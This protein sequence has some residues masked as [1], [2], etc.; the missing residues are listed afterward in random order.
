MEASVRT[1]AIDDSNIVERVAR[2]FSSVR[3]ARPDYT[4]LAAELE[5]TIPF[6]VFGVTLLRYD[7]Q[8]VRVTICQ[9]QG[10]A[11]SATYRQHPLRD[12]Q[13]D[14]LINAPAALI[15]NYPEGLDGTPAEC[16]DALSGF[17]HLHSSF[18]A[19][20]ITEGE[21]IL[22]TLELGSSRLHAYESYALRRLIGAVVRVLANAIEGAQEGGSAAIQNRQ[23]EALKSVSAAL[24]SQADLRTVLSAITGGLAQSLS[25]ATAIVTFDPQTG[26][27]S[28][29]AQTGFDEARLRPVI[30][31]AEAAEV[32]D[33]VRVS[34]FERKVCISNDVATDT[35][36]LAS[37]SFADQLGMR[38]IASQPLVA[39]SR[40]HGALLLCSPEAGGFTPLKTDIL[41]LF[42]T[43]AAIAYLT[44]GAEDT[45]ARTEM[46]D[47]LSRLL[48]HIKQTP[49]Q[50]NDALWV[51]NT[52]GLCVYMN[53]AAEALSEQH[54]SIALGASLTTVLARLAPRIRNA[55]EVAH[56]LRTSLQD[57][58]SPQEV[59]C[60]LA[61]DP[62][63]EQVGRSDPAAALDDIIARISERGGGARASRRSD[64]RWTDRYLQFSH[65]PLL[66][67]QS[68]PVAFVLQAHDISEQ[69]R[70]EQNKSALLSTVSHELRTPLT[71]IKAAV[72][73]LLQE[74]AEW[75]G[76]EQRELLEVV[77]TQADH[78]TLLVNALVEMSRIEMG[79]LA[80]EKT[81]CDVAEIVDGALLQHEHTLSQYQLRT[82]I[83]PG[84]PLVFADERQLERVFT[85]LIDNALRRSPP[86]SPILIAVSVESDPPA[87][88]QGMRVQVI[89]SGPPIQEDERYRI[90]T[91]FYGRNGH[92]IGLSLAICRG[93]IEAHQGKIAVEDGPD[94]SGACFTC[95]IPLPKRGG[96]ESSHHLSPEHGRDDSLDSPSLAVT[97]EERA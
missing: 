89:D 34:L 72:T 4:R 6:D 63:R 44:R 66:N 64:A 16:G 8:G 38:S 97:V 7:R 58:F 91:T 94:D 36:F 61:V 73:G 20:L 87:H 68:V 46:L 75:T 3:G 71:A 30:E 35:R 82:C 86:G 11:W 77:D 51:T 18:I 54:Q 47:E 22:G 90:F 24:T 42:A 2:I 55:A 23:R 43:Q 5:T 52:S 74:D 10:E 41:S 9:R 27:L 28:L 12:S 19:P 15:R 37:R 53:P 69:V 83:Q 78:L 17:P 29:E 79:A 80:L 65:Y 13:A 59:R 95:S 93:I 88:A 21:N 50:A 81:W 32:G 49:E 67:V 45:G 33:I 84:L 1:P 25:A 40:V 48:T 56:F 31:Q 96:Q 62:V 39:G 70:D 92:G 26:A 14:Q 76:Q 57:W 85:Y 60:I